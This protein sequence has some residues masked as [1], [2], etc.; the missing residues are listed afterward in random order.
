MSLLFWRSSSKPNY[1]ELAR[2]VNKLLAGTPLLQKGYQLDIDKL[3]TLASYLL[4]ENLPKQF[5][6]NAALFSVL[7]FNVI[8]V[9]LFDG[10]VE[11][12][13]E[14]AKS[15]RD[16]LVAQDISAPLDNKATAKRIA[17]TPAN[18]ERHMTEDL[19][20][21]RKLLARVRE[22]AIHRGELL[23]PPPTP[24]GSPRTTRGMR[25]GA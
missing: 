13:P 12:D 9:G 7:I 8:I 1:D 14:K 23:A 21:L 22:Q 15:F 20:A 10:T 2:D 19:H 6:K 24:T 11:L 4:D 17:Q 25:A 5:S 18:L 16:S 3:Q